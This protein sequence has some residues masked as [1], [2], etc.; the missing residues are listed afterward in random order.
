[1]FGILKLPK[2]VTT[3]V[4]TIL[5]NQGY[6]IPQSKA[7]AKYMLNRFGISVTQNILELKELSGEDIDK[8]KKIVSEILDN[9]ECYSIKQLDISGNDIMSLGFKGNN[10]GEILNFLLDAV[11]NEKVTNSILSLI[12]YIKN[13]RD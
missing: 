2:A 4:K 12:E 3:D 11:I 10:V 8:A 13:K 6:K 5:S 1:M 9:D 7:E